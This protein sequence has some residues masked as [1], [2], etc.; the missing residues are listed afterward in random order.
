MRTD[1]APDYQPDYTPDT[2]AST[3]GATGM[4]ETAEVSVEAGTITATGYQ[5]APT[6][7]PSGGG[8]VRLGD[9]WPR[10]PEGRPGRGTM[11]PARVQVRPGR[12]TSTGGA[13]G[14]PQNAPGAGSLIPGTIRSRGIQNPADDEILAILAALGDL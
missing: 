6:Y 12:I 14:G 13:L 8:G 10:E 11:R 9:L 5:P 1:F 2:A 4:L 7:Q 3:G